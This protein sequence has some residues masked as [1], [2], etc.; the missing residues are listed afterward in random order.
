M[1]SLLY[2][3]VEQDVAWTKGGVESCK[4]AVQF[5]H[6]A[7]LARK[8]AGSSQQTRSGSLERRHWVSRKFCVIQQNL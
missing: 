5:A 2:T 1:M 8:C 4:P 3:Q 7:V 6:Q